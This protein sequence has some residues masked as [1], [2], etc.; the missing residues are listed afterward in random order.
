MSVREKRR[1]LI[2]V[3]AVCLLIIMLIAL[4]VNVITIFR[5]KARQ[6][7]LRKRLNELSLTAERVDNELDSRSNK[8]YIEKYARENLK[9][10]E[11]GEIVYVPQE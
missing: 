3:A 6:E 10:T 5:L 9:L 4:T 1:Q 8:E 11:D 7:E 2:T